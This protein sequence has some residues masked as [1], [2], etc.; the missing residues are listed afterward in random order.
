MVTIFQM[1]RP[2]GSRESTSGSSKCRQNER[3]W[4]LCKYANKLWHTERSTRRWP[5][6]SK[7][8]CVVEIVAPCYMHLMVTGAAH[9][10]TFAS[11]LWQTQTNQLP[12]NLR[13]SA[14]VN[15]RNIQ[16]ISP[17]F[18]HRLF[19]KCQSCSPHTCYHWAPYAPAWSR[20]H[21][22]NV[23]APLCSSLSLS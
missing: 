17:T 8:V 2:R 9:H 21:Q 3:I 15:T 7:W 4:D 6:S 22:Y 10:A 5:P 11:K 18:L 19:E 20:T 23:N 16:C 14:V 12:W 13:A 1:L